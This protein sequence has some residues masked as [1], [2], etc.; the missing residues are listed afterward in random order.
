[1]KNKIELYETENN[2]SH[3]T[4]SIYQEIDDFIKSHFLIRFNEISLAYEIARIDNKK[5]ETL[6]ESTLLITMVNKG[7]KV[8]YLSLKTYLKSDYVFRYNPLKYY[9]EK[10]PEWDGCDYISQYASYVRTD[11]DKLFSYHLKKWCV[12]TVLSVFYTDKINKHCIVLA[13]GD[14]HVGKSTYLNYLIPEELKPYSAENLA[15]DKDSRIK[16]CKT[17]IINL[18]E[19]D[20]LGSK[21]VN[22]IKAFLSQT[23]VNERLPYAD[24]STNIPRICSFVGSTNRTEILNDDTGSVRWIIFNVMGKLNFS[25]KQEFDI[26]KLWVQAYYLAFNDKSFKPDLSD[27]DVKIN[28]KRNEAYTI[29]TV[30]R[31]LIPTYYQASE[32]MV[33]FRTPTEIVEELRI[34]GH[35]LSNQKIGSALKRFGFRRIKH[36]KRD[37]YGYLAKPLFKNSPLDL[38]STY[39]LT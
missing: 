18:E 7:I 37:V 2:K 26:N 24:K 6:N 10:L 19:L 22:S 15:I 5:F 3:N 8:S 20:V 38:K 4:K 21:D 32:E 1:M 25:Y 27:E 9:F 29:Q 23:W 33:D 30:E 31:E 14:Q 34:L 12:R 35:K 39:L 13:N 16:L 17:F 36:P 11:D 28:E